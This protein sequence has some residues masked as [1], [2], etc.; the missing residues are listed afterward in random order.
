MAYCPACISFDGECHPDPEDY[1][2]PCV[3]YKPGIDELPYEE[4]IK[5]EKDAKLV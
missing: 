3:Y 2:E 4:F 5:E 1:S